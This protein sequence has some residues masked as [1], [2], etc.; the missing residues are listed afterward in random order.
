MCSCQP[1]T[2]HLRRTKVN[3]I[4]DLDSAIKELNPRF[5]VTEV[6]LIREW[7]AGHV[8]GCN[9][10]HAKQV[11][12]VGKIAVELE[13][14]EYQLMAKKVLHDLELHQVWVQK[15]RSV[16]AQ[17]HHAQ[18]EYK[19]RRQDNAQAAAES[20]MVDQKMCQVYNL[21]AMTEAETNEAIKEKDNY[22]MQVQGIQ[23]PS[24][25]VNFVFLNW[26]STSSISS[27]LQEAQ[28]RALAATLHKG[29]YNVGLVVMPMWSHKK[30][31]LFRLEALILEKLASLG[32]NVDQKFSITFQERS[33]QRDDR[34]LSAGCRV[35]T[36]V[37]NA[38]HLEDG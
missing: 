25:V 10:D 37:S 32:L 27:K 26:A 15:N 7:V 6:S 18:Q 5:A 29:K 21:Q 8:E 3:L 34:Q 17:L 30:G 19:R 9:A 28:A 23:E 20:F 4:N 14:D 24:H 36:S 22:T 11:E 16:E 12:K 31:Q 33:D 38:N 2:R 13:Q 1:C 35:V